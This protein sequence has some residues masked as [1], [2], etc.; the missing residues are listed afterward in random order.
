MNG[1]KIERRLLKAMSWRGTA[2]KSRLCKNATI[3]V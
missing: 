2:L 1:E 3:S